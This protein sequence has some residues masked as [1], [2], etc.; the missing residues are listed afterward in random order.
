MSEI[1]ENLARVRERM[2]AAARRA[3]RNFAG[4]RLVAVSKTV[5]I[6]RVTQAIEA[7]AEILGENYVQEARK[8]IEELGHGVAWHFIGHLQT[9]KARTASGLF[10]F[11]HSVDSLNLAEELGRGA[12]RE[13]KILPVLLQVN[14]A[15]EE[16]KFGTAEDETFQLIERISGVQGIVVKGLMTMPPYFEDPEKSRPYFRELRE[17]AEAIGR[18]RIPG[19]SVEELSMGMS[20]DFEVAI[21]EGATI[22]RVGTAIFGP[23]PQE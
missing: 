6:E 4:I 22:V 2:E 9:N 15:R 17:M 5:D 7:G 14:I 13:K 23:R 11:I 18:K 10:D 3:G 21:E 1:S 16:T 19:V 8:K 12:L 20:N